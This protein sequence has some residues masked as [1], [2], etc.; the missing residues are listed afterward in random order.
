MRKNLGDLPSLSSQ[1]TKN[2]QVTEKD[3]E[4]AFLEKGFGVGRTYSFLSPTLRIDYILATK[5]FKVEQF[6]R[7]VRDY[8]DHY[9]LVADLKLED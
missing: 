6:N 5:N 2:I 4:D 7:F 3:L 8:S 9:M 1:Q